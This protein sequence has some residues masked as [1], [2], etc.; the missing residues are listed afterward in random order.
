MEMGL[1]S[2]LSAAVTAY[3]QAQC[4]RQNAMNNEDNILFAHSTHLQLIFIIQTSLLTKS[5]LTST[6][7][8][9]PALW[10]Q[11]RTSRVP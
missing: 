5:S 9:V 4:L 10:P 7:A 6:V 11:H 2:S 3:N 1:N 8:A